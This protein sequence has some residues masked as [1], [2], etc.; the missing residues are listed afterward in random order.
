M[1]SASCR[2]LASGQIDEG[3]QGRGDSPWD[4]AAQS[5]GSGTAYR[6]RAN[7]IDM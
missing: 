4:P 6:T 5:D 1:H 3:R 2:E 7:F